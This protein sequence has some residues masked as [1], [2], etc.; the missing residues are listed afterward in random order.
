MWILKLRLYFVTSKYLIV[1]LCFSE[2]G[3]RS[4]TSQ[5]LIL[6]SSESNSTSSCCAQW[7]LLGAGYSAQK[8]Q[9]ACSGSGGL[10][11][12]LKSIKCSNLYHTTVLQM[13]RDPLTLARGSIMH[14]SAV[15]VCDVYLFSDAR[16]HCRLPDF[17]PV[18]G[19]PFADFCG[20][21]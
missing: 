8:K 17:A 12:T 18:E 19:N 7:E 3:N 13:T 10:D 6:K 2:E 1:I 11:M 15:W 5:F 20:P 9:Y 21:R 4:K 16:T 14:M